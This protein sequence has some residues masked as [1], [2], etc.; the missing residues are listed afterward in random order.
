MGPRSWNDVTL[1]QYR[2]MVEVYGDGADATLDRVSALAGRGRVEV[3][4]MSAQDFARLLQ[5][6]EFTKELPDSTTAP[7]TL[8][9]NARADLN[10]SMTVG[11]YV[12]GETR[13]SPEHWPV[14]VLMSY[15]PDPFGFDDK[16]VLEKI[17]GLP[18]SKAWPAVARY[19]EWRAFLA[20]NYRGL[21]SADPESKPPTDETVAQRRKRIREEKRSRDAAMKWNTWSLMDSLALGDPLRYQEIVKLNIIFSLNWLSYKKETGN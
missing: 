20:H 17:W 19:Q 1:R 3:A 12:D 18:M 5:G 13:Q 2:N 6:L 16:E 8:L 15:P 10:V 21:F 4:R 7:E 11:R 14:V 9:G